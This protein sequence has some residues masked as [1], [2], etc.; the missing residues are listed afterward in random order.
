MSARSRYPDLPL[1]LSFKPVENVAPNVLGT[2]GIAS[3]NE[4]GFIVPVPVL[5]KARAAEL[6]AAF[7][8][9]G[10]DGRRLNPHMRLRWVYELMCDEAIL[11]PVRDLVGPDVICLITQYINKEPGSDRAIPGHQDAAFNPTDARTVVFW[12]ALADADTDNGCMHFVNRSH[13]LGALPVR[14][15]GTDLNVE[16]TAR[17]RAVAD[18]GTTPIVVHAGDAVMFSDLTLHLSPPN[19]STTRPRPAFTMTFAGGSLLCHQHPKA[20][21][22]PVLCCGNHA[23]P[24]WDLQPPPA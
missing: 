3:F 2:Q 6:F 1:D 16:D 15:P 9:A 21:T 4:A 13:T 12:L 10:D 5:S 22:R 8:A 19:H 7:E 17:E 18:L 20:N 23:D 11:G 14:D 24:S